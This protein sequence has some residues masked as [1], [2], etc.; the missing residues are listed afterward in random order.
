MNKIK[1]L[2]DSTGLSFNEIKEALTKA[3][4]DEI[5]A[6]EMLHNLGVKMAAK[7]SS[8][9]VKEGVVESYIHNTRKVGSMVEVMCETDFVARN[10]EF[11]KL[12]KELSMH[13][14]AMKPGNLEE[15]LAQSFIKDQ[16]ITIQDLLNQNIAKL[17]ENIQIG[18]FEVFSL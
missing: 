17:G 1:S 9:E 6:K 14:A 8:R 11:Q 18:R 2:R 16:D 12:A 4:G 13:I 10:V 3:G 7:K 5:K 15:L